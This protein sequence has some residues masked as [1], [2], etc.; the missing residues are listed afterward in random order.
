MIDC[1]NVCKNG[2]CVEDECSD[3]E[4]KCINKEETFVG[5]IWTCINGVWVEED[6]LNQ[7]SCKL[8]DDEHTVCGDCKN[9]AQKCEC[10]GSSCGEYKCNDGV[11]KLSQLCGGSSC[12]DSTTCGSCL[13]GAVRCV[14]NDEK[15]G[16]QQ[17]CIGGN[18]TESAQVCTGNHIIEATKVS[19]VEEN[20]IVL[21]NMPQSCAIDNKSCGSC[22]SDDVICHEIN[23]KAYTFICKN[24]AY[25]VQKQCDKNRCSD[26][27]KDCRQCDEEV[28]LKVCINNASFAG[29]TTECI[30]GKSVTKDCLSGYSCKNNSDCG[31]CVN[32]KTF[33]VSTSSNDCTLQRCV[34]GKKYEETKT[35]ISC[36][37]GPDGNAKFGECI[38]DT[39][40]CEYGSG[41]TGYSL[42]CKNG[43]WESEKCP[44]YCGDDFKCH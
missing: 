41:N 2:S 28:D 14:Q 8:L 20:I 38:N 7:Y 17:T 22:L 32:N 23:G 31:E 11:W 6:C 33:D 30:N 44:N 5:E 10:D 39:R 12:K 43:A 13:D 21:T 15:I 42:F 3:G 9:G 19:F 25:Q 37:I 29:S 4:V 40:K 36:S 34:N 26:D 18:W 1:K 16:A 24:G 27:H 35:N